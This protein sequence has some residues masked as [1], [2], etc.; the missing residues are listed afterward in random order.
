MGLSRRDDTREPLIF[1]FD[2]PPGLCGENKGANPAEYL[3]VA[4]SGFLTTSMVAHA[5]AKDITLEEVSS[6][7]EGDL[8]LQGFIGLSEEGRWDIRYPGIL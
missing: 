7:Y 6:R 2:E 4:L 1:E 3:L 5:A 8:D